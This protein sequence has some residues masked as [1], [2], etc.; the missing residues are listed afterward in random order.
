M[1][2]SDRAI[3]AAR[4]L[5]S[6]GTMKFSLNNVTADYPKY[7][8]GTWHRRVFGADGSVRDDRFITDR[9]VIKMA[10]L[11]GWAEGDTE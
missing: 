4:Y 3:R 1:S 7:E 9:A 6:L 10:V 11:N 2:A 8:G 5:M